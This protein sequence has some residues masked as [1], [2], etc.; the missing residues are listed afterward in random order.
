M[1]SR[2]QLISTTQACDDVD[3]ALRLDII[4]GQSGHACERLGV[5]LYVLRRV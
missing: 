4:V 5:V 3:N 1:P 2:E